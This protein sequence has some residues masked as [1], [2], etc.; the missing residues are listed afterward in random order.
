MSLSNLTQIIVL[1]CFRFFKF[2]MEL[3]CKT[4]MNTLTAVLF[5]LVGVDERSSDSYIGRDFFFRK[6]L[7][8]CSGSNLRFHILTFNFKNQVHLFC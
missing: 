2:G 5:P 8:T 1:N 3:I 6:S 7:K 4:S